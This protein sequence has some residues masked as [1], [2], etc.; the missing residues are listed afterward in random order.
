MRLATIHSL[1]SSSQVLR[2]CLLRQARLEDMVEGTVADTVNRIAI[3]L[4]SS[5]GHKVEV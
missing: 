1:A 3:L 4:D 5:R 2:S